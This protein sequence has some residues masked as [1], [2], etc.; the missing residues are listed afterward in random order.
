MVQFIMI[1]IISWLYARCKPEREW[2]LRRRENLW[3]QNVY[4]TETK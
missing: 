3:K 2:E 1:I 4:T